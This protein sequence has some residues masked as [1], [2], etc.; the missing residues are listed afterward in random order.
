[1]LKL[2]VQDTLKWS[3]KKERRKAKQNQLEKKDCIRWNHWKVFVLIFCIFHGQAAIE[4]AF[5][6]NYD[7]AVINQ[8]KE[9]LFALT[10][11]KGHLNGNNVTA[12]N[13]PIT[14]NMMLKLRG[15][16]TLKRSS[17]KGKKKIKAK[18]TWKER[19]HWC[20]K[21]KSAPPRKC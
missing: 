11:V 19:F 8:S 21:E 6:T 3:S 10:I 12:A 20:S 15:Q 7:C 4:C 2:R 9:S 5:K 16:D 14:R 1:M 17:K 18:L 13:I